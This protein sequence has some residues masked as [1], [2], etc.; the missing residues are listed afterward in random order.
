MHLS[1]NP[2]ISSRWSRCVFLLEIGYTING[3]EPNGQSHD[4]I[5]SIR[6]NYTVRPFIYARSKGLSCSRERKVALV[7]VGKVDFYHT[8]MKHIKAQILSIFGVSPTGHFVS[9]VKCNIILISRRWLLS[10]VCISIEAS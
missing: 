2:T 9:G 3:I 10:Q 4:K 5:I 6:A 8:W 1:V 7:H